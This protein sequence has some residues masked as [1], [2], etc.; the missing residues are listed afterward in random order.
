VRKLGSVAAGAQRLRFQRPEELKKLARARALA[1]QVVD[2][3]ERARKMREAFVKKYGSLLEL[4]KMG[5]KAPK[6]KPDKLEIE[7]A[8]TLPEEWTYV[9]DGKLVIGGLI[10]D[11]V[12]KT[13]KEVLEVLGCYYHA[14]PIHFPDVRMGPK[15]SPVFRESVY[16]ANGYTVQFIW[17]HEVKARRKLAFKESGVRDTSV[18][19]KP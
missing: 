5:M 10:P 15:T 6:R 8:K 3:E 11:F 14:C 17:E 4:A 1:R 12:S 7:V 9:G 16:A 2:P 18:Y 13:R 19:A